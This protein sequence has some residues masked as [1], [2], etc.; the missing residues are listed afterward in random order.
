[1]P[2]FHIDIYTPRAAATHT[3]THLPEMPMSAEEAKAKLQ[4][5]MEEAAAGLQRGLADTATRYKERQELIEQETALE[6]TWHYQMNTV[7]TEY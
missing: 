2:S 3:H 6:G 1:M 5:G 4:R 7:Y